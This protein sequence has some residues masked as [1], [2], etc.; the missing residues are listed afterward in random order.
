MPPKNRWLDCSHS[1]MVLILWAIS[2]QVFATSNSSALNSALPLNLATQLLYLEDPEHQLT[3]NDFISKSPTIELQRTQRPTLSLGYTSAT[4]WIKSALTNPSTS[5]SSLLIELAYSP[6]D[7]VDYYVVRDGA[8][9]ESAK[10]GDR[11]PFTNRLVAHRNYLFPLQLAYQEI[12]DI[13]F[14]IDTTSAVQVPLTLWEERQ[15]FLANEKNDVELGYWYGVMMVM[16]I[17]NLFLFFMIRE[18]TYLFYVIYVLGF[19]CFQAGVDALN[20]QFISPEFTWPNNEGLIFFLGVTTV[21][22]LLF[23]INFLELKRVLYPAYLFATCVIVLPAFSIIGSFIFPYRLM[24]GFTLG[25]VLIVSTTAVSCGILSWRKGVLQARYFTIA[26]LAFLSGCFLLALNK[27]GIVPRVF[28]TE[29]GARI[30]SLIEVVLIS[31][32]LGQRISTERKAKVVAQNESLRNLEHYLSLY[33]NASE[34]IFTFSNG[35]FLSANPS[36]LRMLGYDSEAA[37]LANTDKIYHYFSSTIQGAYFLTQLAEK[38]NVERFEIQLKHQDGYSLWMSI[39]AKQ[40]VLKDKEDLIEGSVIDITQRKDR[41]AEEI[42]RIEAQRNQEIAEAAVK[43]KSEF[44][45][46]MSHEIRTPMNGVIG[47]TELLVDTPLNFKQRQFLK[48]IKTSGQALLTIINDILDYSKIESGNMTIEIIPIHLHSFIDDCVSIFAMK[49]AETKLN[50]I[51]TIAADVPEVIYGDPCRVKQI[52]INLVGNAYKFTQ[53]GEIRIHISA[54]QQDE[55]SKL[56][57]RF[58]IIDTGIGLTSEQQAKLFKAFSQAESS[59]TRKFGGTGLGLSISKKLAQL[60]GGDIGVQSEAGQG[61]RFW[62]TIAAPAVSIDPTIKLEQIADKALVSHWNDLIGYKAFI[63]TD[64]LSFES[65]LQSLFSKWQV[66]TAVTNSLTA[67]FTLIE[68]HKLA[69]L[70]VSDANIAAH[71]IVLIDLNFSTDADLLPVLNAI[72]QLQLE[73][74]TLHFLGFNGE[75]LPTN[76]LF[77]RDTLSVIEKPIT[78]ENLYNQLVYWNDRSSYIECK[79]ALIKTANFQHL[80]VLVAED[81]AINT[82]V[83]KGILQKLGITPDFTIN[84]KE[85]VERVTTQA[86][87]YD[88]ILMDCE[89]PEMD[90]YESTAVIRAHYSTKH[91][92]QENS[93]AKTPLI[94]GLSA[95][96]IR[97]YVDKAFKVGMNDYLTKP[98]SRDDIAGLLNKYFSS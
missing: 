94:V 82:L 75:T 98:I 49:A 46:V 77:S 8:I 40:C 5:T 4:I 61:S 20:Y 92:T 93:A 95:H 44:L 91:A 90:G 9:V 45:A 48:I 28:I 19:I 2:I 96:V 67:A 72:K 37:F 84:G 73:F 55:N 21:S 15:Y 34:G 11:R 54:E 24:M 58:A 85:A 18:K 27:F 59:T 32:A 81:N 7:Q 83:I 36:L 22:V 30:G 33:N 29:Q 35:Q 25:V 80:K 71:T 12:V 53:R 47:M 63:I 50:L 56:Q 89:M 62:F 52:L 65:A 16:A 70:T 69:Q 66:E 26:W 88:L 41:E 13:Y 86:Q 1:I 6:L 68:Q 43:A 87:V 14:K 97:D 38:K 42:L 39:S 31:I 57:L 23:L 51:Y 17:Y 74:L 3:I 60:M 79:P 64:S 76:N 78:A 10:V